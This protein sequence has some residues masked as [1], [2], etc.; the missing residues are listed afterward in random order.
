MSKVRALFVLLA[1]ILLVIVLVLLLQI[2]KLVNGTLYYYGLTFSIDWAQPYWWMFRISLVL[3]IIA[4]FLISVVEL[5][6]PS[7]E[8]EK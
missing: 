7:F 1:D 8:E 2:D 5:P 6:S 4:I 3:I